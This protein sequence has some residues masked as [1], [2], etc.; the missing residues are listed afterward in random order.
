VQQR[1][2]RV[3]LTLTLDLAHLLLRSAVEQAPRR[4][5]NDHLLRRDR[6]Y[7]GFTFEASLR[8]IYIVGDSHD[9]SFSVKQEISFLFYINEV[10]KYR[11]STVSMQNPSFA[12]SGSSSR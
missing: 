11:V 8:V 3:G 6:M 2:E 4:L 9:F 7:T 10:I 1:P 12:L 5:R